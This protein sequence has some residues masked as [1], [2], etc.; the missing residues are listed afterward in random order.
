MLPV[1]VLPAI[2]RF[3]CRNAAVGARPIKR[4]VD[5][6]RSND[7][8]KC[9]QPMVQITSVDSR[10]LL[11]CLFCGRR[12]PAGCNAEVIHAEICVCR[13]TL[14]R[15]VE[16]CPSQ[17]RLHLDGSNAGP[18]IGE[19]VTRVRNRGRPSRII[20]SAKLFMR[21]VGIRIGSGSKP[22]G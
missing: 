2:R 9:G 19:S 16:R 22:H 15:L 20:T 14:R 8:S 1:S 4:R 3:Q 12:A 21:T 13:Q 17:N 5:H 7:A 11:N 6:S 10:N 18:R